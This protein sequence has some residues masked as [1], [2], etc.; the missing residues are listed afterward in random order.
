[1][2]TVHGWTPRSGLRVAVHLPERASLGVV[3]C[4]PVGQEGVIAYQ[5]LR[6]VA[7]E[8]ERRGVASVRFDAPGRGD[9]GACPDGVTLLDGGS[10]AAELL[11]E[12]GC[13]RIAYVGLASGALAASRAATDQDVLVLWDAPN[14][15]RAWLRRQRMLATLTLGQGR[16]DEESGTETIVGA[17]LSK[18]DIAEL[19]AAQVTVSVPQRC[20]VVA[21]RRGHRADVHATDRIEVDGMDKLL[22]SSSL[23]ALIPGAAV[24]AVVDWLV[25]LS[26]GDN[27]AA[28][29]ELRSPELAEQLSGAGFVERIRRLG[30]ERLFAIETLAPQTPADAPVVLLHNG[31]SEHRSG[32]SDYQVALA[33]ELARDGVR[34][35]RF[36][37]RGTGE[38]GE[39]T[40]DSP[41]LMF[42]QTWVDDQDAVIADLGLDGDR[43]AVIGHCVGGWLGGY[44]A[45]YRPRLVVALAQD[46]FRAPSQPNEVRTLHLQEHTVSPLRRR[47]R[48]VFNRWAP[49]RLRYAL[50]R[51][52][53]RGDVA[54]HF[55]GLAANSVPTLLVLTPID[56]IVFDR[57]GGEQ[58][59]RKL[60]G[61][62][63]VLRL[64]DGDHALF[65]R[66]MRAEVIAEVRARVAAVFAVRVPG[67]FRA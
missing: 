1:M 47:A 8:L 43:L 23:T 54:L 39:I 41:D 9:S 15:G 19:E 49:P 10:E 7:E 4:P 28:D 21:R 66:R 17:D 48:A 18:A 37:R 38:S 36:D 51:S 52:G 12:A 57:L 58:A 14:S 35:V 34:A 67:G 13:S 55:E 44:A 46:A 53:V 26:T 62:I 25:A 11:R 24:T 61:P 40:A 64:D 20:L 6:L 59:L 45:Q 29:V 5:T 33:R 32:A 27:A 3:L 22:D 30:P 50:S 31:S 16:F 63:D 2:S 60:S 42:T 65:S 56:S